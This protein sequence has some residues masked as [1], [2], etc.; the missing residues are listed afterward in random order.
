MYLRIKLV[1]NIKTMKEVVQDDE[2]ENRH[3]EQPKVE[4][5]FFSR[6][7]K[8]SRGYYLRFYRVF[9]VLR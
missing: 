5:N 6:G 8:K 9:L 1:V 3:F 4:T 7:L 2:N